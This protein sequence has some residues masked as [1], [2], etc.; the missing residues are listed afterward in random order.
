[1]LTKCPRCKTGALTLDQDKRRYCLMCGGYPDP[2]PPLS[3]VIRIPRRQ[4]SRGRPK[5]TD[6]ERL[7]R[8]AQASEKDAKRKREKRAE[9]ARE[10]RY[11]E[12]HCISKVVGV[13]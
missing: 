13:G 8:S 10:R 9:A 12:S 11:R 7:A 6:E 2:I 1:M 3:S 5:L 4:G